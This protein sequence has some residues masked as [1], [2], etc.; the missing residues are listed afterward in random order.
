MKGV[1]SPARAPAYGLK[2]TQP[3]GWVCWTCCCWGQRQEMGGSGAGKAGLIVGWSFCFHEQE[4]LALEGVIQV[5]LGS[6][7]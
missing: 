7:V 4:G 2:V 3:A 1:R 6:L 5:K